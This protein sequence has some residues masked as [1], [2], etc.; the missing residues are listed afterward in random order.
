MCYG[1]IPWSGIT[2]LVVGARKH[3]A[4]S[5]GF[6]EGPKP[7]TWMQHLKDRGIRIKRDVLRTE[8]AAVLDEY[9]EAGMPVYNP[10]AVRKKSKKQ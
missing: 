4:E 1:A 5:V 7:R 10:R 3:D 6:D 2:T 8:A 9:H